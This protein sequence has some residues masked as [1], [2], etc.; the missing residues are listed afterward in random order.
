MAGAPRMNGSWGLVF[1]AHILAD[2]PDWQNWYDA[3]RSSPLWEVCGFEQV[4][5]WQTT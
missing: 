4:P 2:N 3:N 5:S 1:L